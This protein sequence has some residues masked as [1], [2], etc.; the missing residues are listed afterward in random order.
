MNTTTLG[1]RAYECD[2]LGHVNNAVYLQYLQHATFD[3]FGAS[4]D[5][6]KL[7]IEYHTPAKDRDELKIESWVLNGAEA[8][9]T[10]G[11]EIARV[12]DHAPVVRAQ[13]E[14]QMRDD[15]ARA[16]NADPRVA[17]LKPFAPPTDN[18]ARPFRWRHTVRRYEL[19]SMNH[20]ALAAYFNWL[21]EATYQYAERVGWGIA[22]L[23]Q[24]NFIVL[25]RRHDA[26][27]FQPA[28]YGDEIELV[29]RLI[30]VERVRGIW[31][32][33]MFRRGTPTLLLRDYS[34]GA[35]LDWDGNIKPALAPMMDALLRGE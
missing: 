17:P 3:A 30:K 35:F 6:R 31:I 11:Y 15:P 24:E 9:V 10:C 26:E 33:E 27:F 25:Q 21:E 18:A 16:L 2:S 28:Q 12:A 4:Q 29:S 14:W 13:I 5:A 20:V 8:R 7:S 22:R 23:K 1:V 19:D 34:T 32:H